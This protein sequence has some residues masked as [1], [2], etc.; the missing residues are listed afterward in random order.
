MGAKHTRV[1][2]SNPRLNI[3][4]EFDICHAERLLRMRNNGGWQIAEGSEYKYTDHGIE[5]IGHTD[6]GKRA[7]RQRGD[8]PGNSSAELD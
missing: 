2:L 5:Y 3:T 7:T 4:E 1:P 6:T 8:K